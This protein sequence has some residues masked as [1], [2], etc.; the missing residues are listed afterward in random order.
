MPQMQS[1]LRTT[2]LAMLCT[3]LG[4]AA[5]QA[6]IN[7]DELLGMSLEQLTNIEVTSVS[8]KKEKATEAA[9]AVYVITDD[10]IRRLGATSIPEAL[11]VVPGMNVAQS[12]SHQ[13]AVTARGFNGQF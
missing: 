10:D 1:F 2:S 13:W 11:R 8:K 12:G 4:G 7:P 3:V 5:A 9:A 6:D